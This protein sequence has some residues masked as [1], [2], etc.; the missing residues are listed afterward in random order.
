LKNYYHEL[1]SIKTSPHSIAI[2]FAVGTFLSILPTPGLSILVGLFI[3]FIYP[4]M[5]KI[6]L[7]TSY[8]VWNPFVL[9]PIYILSYRLGVL[10]SGSA[11]TVKYQIVFFN[12]LYNF[13]RIYLV[14]SL[15]IALGI[16]LLSYGLVYLA[17]SRYQKKKQ[18]KEYS[19]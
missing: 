17:V 14:G 11:E 6:S 16:S 10:I 5:S 13:T 9:G 19:I 7:F 3:L 8:I 15:I 18:E 2:G 12:Q 1:L 4:R